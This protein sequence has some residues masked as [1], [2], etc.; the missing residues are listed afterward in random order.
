MGP[1]C[2]PARWPSFPCWKSDERNSAVK[3]RPPPV[4]KPDRPSFVSLAAVWYGVVELLGFGV[5]WYFWRR[6]WF[7]LCLLLLGTIGQRFRLAEGRSMSLRSKLLQK[8][9]KTAPVVNQ[10]PINE[11]ST[12]EG[13]EAALD[14]AFEECERGENIISLE[15]GNAELNRE[16]ASWVAEARKKLSQK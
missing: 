8:Q 9:G 6:V 11:D 14:R 4:P 12:D 15:E 16:I 3:G 5:P 13:E 1:R 7:H 2:L 10:P